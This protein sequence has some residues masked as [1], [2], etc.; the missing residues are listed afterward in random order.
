[1][2]QSL[3]PG[4]LNIEAASP[5][6]AEDIEFLTCTDTAGMSQG[7]KEAICQSYSAKRR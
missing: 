4:D 6:A 2:L 5:I 3:L 7:V 1:M